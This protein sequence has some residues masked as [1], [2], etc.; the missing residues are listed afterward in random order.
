MAVS[1]RGVDTTVGLVVPTA[2]VMTTGDVEVDSI[3]GVFVDGVE[4]P[5]AGET[6][7]LV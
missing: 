7:D 2:G 3:A 6:A 5:A 4:V 1:F